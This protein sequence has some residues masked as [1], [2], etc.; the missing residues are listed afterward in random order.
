MGRRV[1]SKTR[2]ISNRG[3]YPRFIGHF[4]SPKGPVGIRPFDA[5]GLPG[6]TP[7]DSVSALYC[8]VYLEWC[9]DVVSFDFEPTEYQFPPTETLP[10]LNCIPDYSVV[11]SSGEVAVREAKYAEDALTETEREKLTIAAKHF[12]QRGIGHETVFR[13]NLEA[14]GFIDTIFLLRRFGQLSYSAELVECAMNRLSA[15]GE[16]DLRTWRARAKSNGVTTSLLYYLL[17]HQDLPLKYKPLQFV[18][19]LSCQD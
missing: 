19:L 10:S 15:L 1:K 13:L 4:P 16:A 8:A 12:A 14:S 7:F 6:V 5:P 11:L 17:Y 3:E 18:E 9:T 2:T